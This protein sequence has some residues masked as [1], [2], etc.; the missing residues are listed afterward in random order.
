MKT[1][2]RKIGLNASSKGQLM[3]IDLA[4]D[5]LGARGVATG[6]LGFEPQGL[7]NGLGGRRALAGNRQDLDATIDDRTLATAVRA[8]ARCRFLR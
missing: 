8:P 2:A 4:G 7:L 6:G 1:T 5:G 3:K